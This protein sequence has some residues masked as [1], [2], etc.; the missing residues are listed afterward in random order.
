MKSFKIGNIFKIGGI[1]LASLFLYIGI[2]FIKDLTLFASRIQV[3][4]NIFVS[5]S[6]IF[7]GYQAF[8][9]KKDY[10]VRNKKHEIEK[11]IQIAE[12]YSNEILSNMAYLFFI[13]SQLGLDKT[14]SEI[15]S[16]SMRQFDKDE[17]NDVIKVSEQEKI[18]SKLHII[19]TKILS[20]A[21]VLLRVEKGGPL[22]DKFNMYAFPVIKGNEKLSDD[23][24]A[25]IL[26]NEFIAVK[27]ETLNKLEY[28]CMYF[29]TGLAN[30]EAIY[31]S[32][33]QTFLKSVCILY[34]DIANANITGKDKYYTNII[35][36]FNKWNSVYME[37]HNKECE[38]KRTH[39]H[40]GV[41]VSS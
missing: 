16:S 19:N 33:H 18:T 36:L 10:V 4:T 31:Q 22:T 21:R 2:H 3:I 39:I 5:V 1:I 17:L 35:K 29:N 8:M 27:Q 11:A 30:D 14:F 37:A 24:I 20:E 26:N 41:R 40:Q 34:Y 38:V 12:I 28:I 9:Y 13:Y 32:I 23:L 25:K 6:V 15:K 7:V